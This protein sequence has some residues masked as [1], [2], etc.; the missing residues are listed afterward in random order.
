MSVC[1]VDG[2]AD[3]IH[4]DAGADG[5]DVVGAQQRDHRSPARRERPPCV[6]MTSV[7]SAA[8]VIRHLAA[9]ISGRWR[10]RSCRWQRCGWA[11]RSFAER[12]W[13][14]PERNP[15]RRRAG[16]RPWRRPPA[17]SPRRRS[18]CRGCWRRP[19]PDHRGSTAS[20]CGDVAVADELAVRVVVSG[21]ERH[22]FVAQPHQVFR[23][24]GKDDRAVARRSR[25]TAGGC[26]WGRG[27]R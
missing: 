6:M 9:R 23:L 26:R 22:D 8:D 24:A 21:R 11:F 15:V 13:R 19:S 16:S 17:A 25:S 4:A 1:L 12:Q 14:T 18:A 5:G 2:L 3:Q 27:R 20:T 10:P 7:W